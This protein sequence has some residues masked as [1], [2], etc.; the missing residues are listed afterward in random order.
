[1]VWRVSPRALAIS[2]V[3]ADFPSI[4]CAFSN[5]LRLACGPC[6]HGHRRKRG[7]RFRPPLLY[8]AT[9]RA[10]LPLQAGNV[11]AGIAKLK[12]CT[13]MAS[14]VQPP[15]RSGAQED[16]RGVQYG[17][18]IDSRGTVSRSVRRIELFVEGAPIGA[19]ATARTRGV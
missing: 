15:A 2:P 12:I 16:H 19:R 14:S 5:C 17:E 10:H 7:R 11:A 6:K 3:L 8:L 18:P 1:M 9:N 4:P 13:S